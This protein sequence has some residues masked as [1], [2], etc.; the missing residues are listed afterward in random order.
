M[1]VKPLE[2]TLGSGE[3]LR[4]V[5]ILLDEDREDAYL[6]LKEVLKPQVDRATREQ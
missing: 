1:I 3:L 6:F 4:R 5:K 2:I